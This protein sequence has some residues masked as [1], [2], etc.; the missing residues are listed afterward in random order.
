MLVRH[1][2]VPV[3]RSYVSAVTVAAGLVA[4]GCAGSSGTTGGSDEPAVASPSA[5]PAASDPTAA[6][7]SSREILSFDAVDG[8]FRDRCMAC[9]GGSR[10]DAGL[11]MDSWER[12]M[13]GSAFGEAVIPY[14]PANSLL[15]E[16][17]TQR[18]GGAHPGELGTDT[19]SAA[20]LDAVRAWIAEGAASASGEFAFAGSR[21]FVY[22]TN[23][24]EASISVI[25][26]MTNVVA[27][28][29]DLPSL[30]FSKTS[31]PHHVAVEPDGAYWYVSLIGENRVLKFDAAHRLVDEVDFEVPGML[32]LDPLSDRL[33]V[34]RS[35][36]AVSAP[37]RIGVI[38]TSDMSVEEIDVFIPRPHALAVAPGGDF[39]FTASLAENTVVVVDAMTLEVQLLRLDG[40]LQVLVQFAVA[41]G[42]GTMVAGGQLSGDLLFFDITAAPAVREAGSLTVGFGPW[43]PVY[44]SDGRWLYVPNKSA[45][46][47]TVV[48]AGARSVDK[49]LSGPAI[50][51]PHGSAVSPDGRYV[52]VSNNNLA[53]TYAPRH[54]L[55]DN[56]NVGTVAVIDT[57]TNEVVKVLEVGNNAAGVG[58][59]V[60]Q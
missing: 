58:T 55:G 17:A 5:A 52:Y 6:G 53:G 41:P 38:R 32:A 39:V 35:M 42:G 46:T 36:T 50:A 59:R 3:W 29:V 47:L 1:S 9:H 21:D 22:V 27:R 51:E 30:G 11:R 13:E 45:N 37:K 54:D 56:A 15:V 49:V 34:G 57:H 10:S 8:I 4:A 7:R 48:D 44:S 20:E 18:I 12:L 60:V 25:D 14:D 28:T 40:G 2:Y 24:D 43:H 19:L 26:A 33:Y 31:R 23:Q 16:L